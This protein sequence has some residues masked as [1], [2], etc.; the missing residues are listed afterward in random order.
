ME[1]DI[2]VKGFRQAE[3]NHG[4]HYM[5]LVGDGDSS[6]LRSIHEG[7]PEWGRYVRKKC[8]NHALKN[9][10]AKL[11]LIVKENPTFKGAGGLIKKKKSRG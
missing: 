2:L 10:R 11:E 4:V 8:V 9:Y 3:T 1:S 5:F 6:V 7:V